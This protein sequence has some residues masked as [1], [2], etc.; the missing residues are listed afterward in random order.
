[1][2]DSKTYNV[3]GAEV[4]VT[5]NLYPQQ[6]EV[7]ITVDLSP[8]DRS[9]PEHSPNNLTEY[10]QLPRYGTGDSYWWCKWHR[11]VTVR[12]GSQAHRVIKHALARIDDAVASAI[13]AREARKAQMGDIFPT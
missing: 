11:K 6:I 3:R 4:I 5:A 9:E 8:L 10:L 1:M 12:T 13:I 2:T 7:H